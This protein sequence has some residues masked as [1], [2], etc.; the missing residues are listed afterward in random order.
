MRFLMGLVSG[1][2]LAGLLAMTPGY[3]DWVDQAL[4]GVQAKLSQH[5]SQQEHTNPEPLPE[6]QATEQEPQP[7]VAVVESAS[8]TQ[9]QETPDVVP[10]E[11]IEEILEAV[12]SVEVEPMAEFQ[13]AWIPFRSER[14]AKGFAE[15]LSLQ[16][17]ESFRVVRTGPGKYEVGFDASSEQHRQQV[18][19]AIAAMT[20]YANQTRGEG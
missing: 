8:P 19:A 9:V 2:I 11:T 12:E 20:G 14:S 16:V 15:K 18:L 7:Q 10:V 13:V 6:Q 3:R 1:A 5:A 17:N 4:T